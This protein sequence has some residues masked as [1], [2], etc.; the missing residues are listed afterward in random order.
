MAQPTIT[1][2][3]NLA[4]GDK[5]S[6]KTINSGINA[7]SITEG[8]NQTWDF[9]NVQSA[10]EAVTSICVN[11]ASTPFAD[12]TEVANSNIAIKAFG[13]TATDTL[14]YVFIKVA[15]NKHEMIALGISAP[16][17]NMFYS[18]WLDPMVALEFPF[19]YG[20]SY[21]D[22]YVMWLNN[23]L[24]NTYILKDTTNMQV[25]AV[26]YGTVKT[27]AGIFQNALMI[28]TVKNWIWWHN[29]D[30]I[31]KTEGTDVEYLWFV[32]GIKLPV[33]NIFMMGDEV[34]TA[35]YISHTEMAEGGLGDE[36]GGDDDD[37]DDDEPYDPSG[38]WLNTMGAAGDCYTKSNGSL[39]WTMG[40]AVIGTLNASS[41]ILTQGFYQPEEFATHVIENKEDTKVVV[42]PNPFS[43]E[44]IIE[45]HNFTGITNVAI[46][47]VAGQ[48]LKIFV[49]DKTVNRLP[50]N[51]LKSGVYF[52]RLPDKNQPRTF[53]IIKK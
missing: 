38:V 8:A 3:Y 42:Y 14:S 23:I 15:N 29:Y 27:P 12:S 6:I 17:T 51:E 39:S 30:Y 50:L 37:D 35:S 53:T 28:K 41:Y 21:S 19:T 16:S 46:Y 47:S 1:Q 36:N 18:K 32:P 49:I 9:S 2:V 45:Y 43:S 31:Y 13:N 4:I 44:I 7:V 40:E 24:E 11:I 22:K 25:S 52:L 48:K 26:G 10:N 5:F 20:D 33:L 34:G